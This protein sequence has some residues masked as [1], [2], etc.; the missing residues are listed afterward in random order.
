MI[1]I[2]IVQLIKTENKGL[3]VHLFITGFGIITEPLIKNLLCRN[4]HE[5]IG[6]TL[7]P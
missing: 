7:E 2:Q 6:F 3:D 4:G 5:L 1:R